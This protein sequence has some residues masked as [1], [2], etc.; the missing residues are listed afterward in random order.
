M[1]AGVRRGRAVWGA[2]VAVA[3]AAPPALAARPSASFARMRE[4]LIAETAPAIMQRSAS[5]VEIVTFPNRHARP[6][7]VLRGISPRTP[8]AVAAPAPAPAKRPNTV[9][10]VAFANP[11][12]RPVTVIRGPPGVEPAVELFAP[13]READ[14]DLV[15]FAVDGAESSHGADLRMWRPDDWRGPQGPM[16][17]SEAA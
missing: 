2:A 5:S 9:E 14:L 3:L 17:V 11:N 1:A 6:V 13:A 12:F 10:V 4:R 16:Q 7:R 15:A 8:A